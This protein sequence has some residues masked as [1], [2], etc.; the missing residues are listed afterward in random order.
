M[1]ENYITLVSEVK[2]VDEYGD[3]VS[4]QSERIVFAELKS[5]TQ[6]EFYQAEAVGL[7]PEIKFVIADYLD[8]KNEQ[9]VKYTPFNGD[10][11]LYSVLRTYRVNNQ[12]EIVCKRG[13][14]D[15]SS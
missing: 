9:I 11:E 12:L 1:Y 6:S 3:T 13:I 8:Y 10:E 7:K 5:I 15:V 2:S 4:V 14:E